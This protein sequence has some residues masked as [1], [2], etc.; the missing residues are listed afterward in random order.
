MR[1]FWGLNGTISNPIQH[2]KGLGYLSVCYRFAASPPAA[3]TTQVLQKSFKM[4]Y[5]ASTAQKPI[6]GSMTTA[7][8]LNNTPLV[9]PQEIFILSACPLSCQKQ[10]NYNKRRD[11]SF[12]RWRRVP[13]YRTCLLGWCAVQSGTSLSPWWRRLYAPQT[14]VNPQTIRHNISEERHLHFNN[15]RFTFLR[16]RNCVVLLETNTNRT[17][18]YLLRNWFHTC[19][20]C[21]C[22]SF[23]SQVYSKL[24]LRAELLTLHNNVRT[25]S[26]LQGNYV[27]SSELL[28]CCDGVW[29]SSAELGL[30]TAHCP[31]QRGTWVNTQQGWAYRHAKTKRLRKKLSHSHFFHKSHMTSSKSE[32]GPRGLLQGKMSWNHNASRNSVTGLNRIKNPVLLV[33]NSKR[34]FLRIHYTLH[35]RKLNRKFSNPNYATNFGIWKW[36]KKLH[37]ECNF[38]CLNKAKHIPHLSTVLR[39]WRT[40]STVTAAGAN[41]YTCVE[42]PPTCPS[43][44]P[45]T[46]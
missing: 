1:C 24:T 16:K 5:D 39:R 29:F 20:D 27:Q 37:S 38:L 15:N 22:Y 46:T 42:K 10:S 32:H 8:H 44:V 34:Y 21:W 9:K 31:C 13:R 19:V 3:I 33:T 17:K 6:S 7:C 14:S 41:T 12:S 2:K 28:F 43:P 18:R 11:F 35:K 45:V 4:S 23:Q 30:L 40:E 36:T 25:V 26:A